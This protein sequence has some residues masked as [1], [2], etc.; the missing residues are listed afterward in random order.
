MLTHQELV[1]LA[2]LSIP[3][4]LGLLARLL[5]RPRNTLRDLA[6]ELRDLISLRMVLRG[7]RPSQR[8]DLLRAHR[9]W[10]TASRQRRT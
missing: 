10:R 1:L 4:L 6:C 8:A 5:R 2:S 3:I 7:T 9:A